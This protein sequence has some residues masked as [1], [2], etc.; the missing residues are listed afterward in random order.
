MRI[1]DWMKYRGIGILYATDLFSHFQ[2]KTND[3][4][5]VSNG[6]K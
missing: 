3:E 1:T 4:G 6:N 5:E 2:E